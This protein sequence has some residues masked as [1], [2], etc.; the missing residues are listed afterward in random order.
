MI[1]EPLPLSNLIGINFNFLKFFFN[2]ETFFFSEKSRIKP[3][4][5][6]PNNFPP[7][8]PDFFAKV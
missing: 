2:L 4:L 3:P 7:Y 8:E 1:L 6:A 5:P